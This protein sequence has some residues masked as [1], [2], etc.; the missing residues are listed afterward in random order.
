MDPPP[1]NKS[2]ERFNREMEKQAAIVAYHQS[3]TLAHQP[4]SENNKGNKL[5]Q[6]MGWTEGQGLGRSNQGRTDIIETEARISN[7][8]LGSKNASYGAGAGDCD[9]KTYIK[10]M[11]K[12]R[13]II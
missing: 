8:G 11:M 7:A 6:K 9:Y 5:L 10:K 3:S 4:I 12:S 2:R 1:V 13:Y